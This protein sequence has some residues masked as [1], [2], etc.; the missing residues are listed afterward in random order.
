VSLMPAAAALRRLGAILA[1]SLGTVD[2]DRDAA[3]VS[4]TLPTCEHA[5]SSP[6]SISTIRASSRRGDAVACYR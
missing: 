6:V 5:R 2:V 4:S 1:Q 3:Q